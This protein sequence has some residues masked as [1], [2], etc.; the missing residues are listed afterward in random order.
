[1]SL[2]HTPPTPTVTYRVRINSGEWTEFQT[3]AEASRFV[4]HNIYTGRGAEV[5]F[6]NAISLPTVL[7]DF[8][9]LI[10]EWLRQLDHKDGFYCEPNHLGADYRLYG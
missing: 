10:D 3:P 2:P 8:N 7:N 1:M 9:K 4:A 6:M 5:V